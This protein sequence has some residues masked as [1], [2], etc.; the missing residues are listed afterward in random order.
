MLAFGVGCKI[1]K[2]LEDLSLYPSPSP[3]PLTLGYFSIYRSQHDSPSNLAQCCIL[4]SRISSV[5]PDVNSTF[6]KIV[7]LENVP[8]L[9]LICEYLISINFWEEPGLLILDT[10]THLST[11]AHAKLWRG[12]MASYGSHLHLQADITNMDCVSTAA[13]EE[14]KEAV[15]IDVRNLDVSW[16][17]LCSKYNQT[18]TC[19]VLLICSICLPFNTEDVQP[20]ADDSSVQPAS[21]SS[22]RPGLPCSR[23]ALCTPRT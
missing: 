1:G 22:C 18:H 6:S 14:L 15:A 8:F 13:F 23:P 19:L 9:F 12:T 3:P 2:I 7:I 10:H 4:D 21:S 11:S 17:I 16:V 5:C 20:P